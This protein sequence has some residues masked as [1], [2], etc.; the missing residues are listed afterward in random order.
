MRKEDKVYKEY[1]RAVG[2]QKEELGERLYSLL[3]QHAKEVSA[4]ILREISPDVIAEILSRVFT[5]FD[6]FRGHCLFSTWVHRIALNECY[7]ELRRREDNR[8][9][10]IEDLSESEIGSLTTATRDNL[11]AVLEKVTE[12]LRGEEERLV[13]LIKEGLSF[14]EIDEELGLTPK[15]T[16]R[17][18][19]K[20]KRKLRGGFEE[21]GL[22]RV[23]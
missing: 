17:R 15:T 12:G 14:L 9:A 3:S 1:K 6:R 19:R 23:G 5:K 11:G 20:L 4:N 2:Q 18:W 8:E 22:R 16:Q 21:L 10:S 7:R 13:E